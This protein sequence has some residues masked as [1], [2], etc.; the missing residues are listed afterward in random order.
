MSTG[1]LQLGLAQY[2]LLAVVALGWFLGVVALGYWVLTDASDRG[3]RAP[4]FD[5]FLAVGF[6]PYLLL[7]LY[8]RGERTSPPTSRELLARD[9][10]VVLLGAFLAG[11][12]LAPPDPLTGALWTVPLMVGG[13]LVV[14]YR[15]WSGASG[16]GGSTA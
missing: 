5:A 14:G 9:S 16:G 2:G 4:W 15:H 1:P 8:W 13:G 3:R 7:Y 11:A 6:A 10:A 12:I